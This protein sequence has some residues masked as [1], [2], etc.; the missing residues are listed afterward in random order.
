[1]KSKTSEVRE[2]FERGQR[3]RALVVAK[4]FRLGFSE[5]E[6]AQIKRGYECLLHADFYEKIGY[7][8]RNEVEKAIGILK[9]KIIPDS[10]E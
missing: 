5:E 10:G 1:M 7:V 6:R 8:A 3:E 4:D 2:L 9:K